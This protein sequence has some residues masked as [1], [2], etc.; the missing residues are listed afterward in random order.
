MRS[1][2]AIFIDF[3]VKINILVHVGQLQVKLAFMSHIY[4]LPAKNMENSFSFQRFFAFLWSVQ[5]F[6]VLEIQSHEPIL[7][8]GEL[9]CT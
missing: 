9:T 2:P 3:V 1:Y 6:S 8:L 4:T 5:G 7:L